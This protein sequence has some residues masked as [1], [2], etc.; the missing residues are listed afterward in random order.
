MA[1]FTYAFQGR[2]AVCS[3]LEALVPFLT[4]QELIRPVLAYFLPILIVR[5]YILKILSN[6]RLLEEGQF[7]VPTVDPHLL[8]EEL[9]VVCNLLLEIY[10]LELFL[11]QDNP[12]SSCH[13]LRVPDMKLPN[14][15]DNFTQLPVARQHEFPFSIRS[16][17]LILAS[18]S[19]LN[20]HQLSSTI[21]DSYDQAQV[22]E[23]IIF[24]LRFAVN[25]I[26]CWHYSSYYLFLAF[27]YHILTS[28]TP[29]TD[30][31]QYPINPDF[32]SIVKKLFEPRDND[33]SSRVTLLDY[34]TLGLDFKQI[35]LKSDD[36]IFLITPL[37]FIH[38]KR[39]DAALS[40][41]ASSLLQLLGHRA[42]LDNI[43]DLV[44]ATL[45]YKD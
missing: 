5:F 36:W 24:L 28:K 18:S 41:M 7:E 37:R 17:R 9:E 44:L 23:F 8:A 15:F 35:H 12:S 29:L 30:L 39:F 6:S 21:A 32:F 4:L 2:I 26:D 19:S 10:K 25:V 45:P 33:P 14:A 43:T 42:Y 13:S 16:T 31:S 20:S 38:G 3:F 1:R 11:R 27:C 34:L 22:Y 40:G